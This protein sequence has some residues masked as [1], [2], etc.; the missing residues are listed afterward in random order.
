MLRVP[1]LLECLTS[2][3]SL[4]RSL[5]P[6]RIRRL[7]GLEYSGRTHSER[8]H[9]SPPVR[10]SLLLKSFSFAIFTPPFS[11]FDHTLPRPPPPR[12]LQPACL[13]VCI[14][15]STNNFLPTSPQLY[16]RECHFHMGNFKDAAKSFDEATRLGEKCDIWVRRTRC[17][18][19][20]TPEVE[21][22]KTAPAPASSLPATPSGDVDPSLSGKRTRSSVKYREDW[23][24]TDG[25]VFITLFAKKLKPEDVSVQFASKSVHM[26]AVL[27]DGKAYSR[28]WNLF[29]SV[30]TA[31]SS[32]KVTPYKVE[33]S[34]NKATVPL[35]WD[36]LE[37]VESTK[38]AA[39]DAAAAAA[40]AIKKRPNE[41]RDEKPAYPYTGKK[42][43]WDKL[44]KEMLE[45]E[46]NEK[47]E[48]DAALMKLFQ[49]IYKDADE[50]TRRAMMKSY[51]TSGGTVLSTNWK[52][53]AEKDYEK[54][55]KAP[56]GREI[57]KPDI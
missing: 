34:M 5:L 13:Y 20:A 43:E 39:D 16:R 12:S 21:E 4:T 25:Q 31:S 53:V 27:P 55:L 24:Q 8:S 19:Q 2:V 36:S 38:R 14:T 23:Y 32:Y 42:I 26:D 17:H 46:K 10:V 47:P 11:F 54:D 41:L 40:A 52:E 50:D 56:K 22:T 57:Y 49:T 30:D 7:G 48:G 51:Q 37:D 1:F 18:V 28:T 15:T 6:H 29:D 33:L 3:F 44:D 9:T 45:D 35:D